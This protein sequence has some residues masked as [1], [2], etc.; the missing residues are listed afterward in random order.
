MNQRATR[1]YPEGMQESTGAHS[2][3]QEEDPKALR[4]RNLDRIL[5][6]AGQIEMDVDGETLVRLRAM[7]V[8]RSNVSR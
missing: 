1:K 5:S 3:Q 2:G 7:S 8:Q 4:R 6:H